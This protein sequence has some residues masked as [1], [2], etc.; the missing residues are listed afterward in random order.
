MC[1]WTLTGY[2]LIQQQPDAASPL[3]PLLPPGCEGPA[4]TKGQRS[5]GFGD[6]WEPIPHPGASGFSLFSSEQCGGEPSFFPPSCQQHLQ[7]LQQDALTFLESSPVLLPYLSMSC[8]HPCKALFS[9]LFSHPS[10][11]GDL[12]PPPKEDEPAR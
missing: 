7:C 11:F 3:G 2:E 6:S 1:L 5:A 8:P 12:T 4:A 10:S 9:F